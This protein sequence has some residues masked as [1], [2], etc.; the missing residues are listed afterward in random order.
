MV[1]AVLCLVNRRQHVNMYVTT[2]VRCVCCA[3]L[4]C[5]VLCCA[6]LCCAVLCCAVLCRG[7]LQHVSNLYAPTQAQGSLAV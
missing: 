1:C 6:V 5:A 3:V 4:C 7:A 2:I